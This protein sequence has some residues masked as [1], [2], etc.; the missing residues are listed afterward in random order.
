M[1]MHGFDDLAVFSDD[2]ICIQGLEVKD[3]RSGWAHIRSYF[4]YVKSGITKFN[5]GLGNT[6]G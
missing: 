1:V 5:S 2:F 6:Y 3:M 4:P